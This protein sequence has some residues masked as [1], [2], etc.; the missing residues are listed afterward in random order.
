[1]VDL[2][3]AIAA[4]TVYPDRARVTRSGKATLEAGEHRIRVSP[5]PLELV[6]DSIR[7]AGRGEVTVLGVDIV[8]ERQ[9]EP[10]DEQVAELTARRDEVDVA[11][12]ELADADRAADAR[13]EFL[14]RLVHKSAGQLAKASDDRVVAFGDSLEAQYGAVHAGRRER[15]R[16]RQDHIREKNS[17]E[18]R[19]ADLGRKNRPDIRA[20][21]ITVD[22]AQPATVELELSYVVPG[23]RWASTYDLRIDEN[24]LSLRWFGLVSQ[25]TGEDWPECRLELST[26]RPAVALDVPELD[27]WYLSTTPPEPK[28]RA[29]RSSSSGSDMDIPSF[30]RNEERA[31]APAGA[32]PQLPP[33]PVREA[34]STVAHGTTAATY[35]PQRPV[36]IAADGTE[37]RT[38]I[39]ALDL[40]ADLDHVT[41]PIRSPEAILRA[42]ARNTSE[43]TLPK[44]RAS[45]F[46]DSEY[47]GATNLDIWAPG[48]ERELALGVDDRIRVE[49]EL[50]RRNAS[51]ATLGS[52]RRVEMEYTITVANHGTRPT[53]VTVLDRL[54]IARDTTLTVRDTV[55][56]PPPAERGDLG[57][58][59]WK[60]DL[61]PQATTTITLGYR[62]EAP[63]GVTVFG[64]P[65]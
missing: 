12:T 13:V 16:L 14:Q 64:L 7:V 49:R 24:G 51:K 48:E 44:G 1:M 50:V 42:T 2:E 28:R 25:S 19:L 20:A 21:I 43:H 59:T 8:T 15:A 40:E 5:L 53:V 41:A 23:A 61:A 54:P 62:V 45:L 22:A 39:T 34:T 3:T 57:I 56:K 46:N 55:L 29:M 58:L 9:P 17:L 60:L 33:V 65:D 63:K 6:R 47:V 38:L 35:S 31:P 4:V 26:A 32:P 36:A 30:M 11:L 10:S 52:A 27:P 37:H 18:R